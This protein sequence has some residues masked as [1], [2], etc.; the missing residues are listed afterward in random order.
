MLER[1]NRWVLVGPDSRVPV[2]SRCVLQRISSATETVLKTT[3]REG[4]PKSVL[5]VLAALVV[6]VTVVGKRK[7]KSWFQSP[8]GSP[9]QLA[10]RSRGA[11]A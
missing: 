6:L 11:G 2:S 1:L 10:R 9:L 8:D 5:C 7:I 4:R 3:K